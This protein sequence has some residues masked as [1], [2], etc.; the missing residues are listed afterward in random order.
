MNL[1]GN[2]HFLDEHESDQEKYLKQA[3][4]NGDLVR[5]WNGDLIDPDHAYKYDGEWFGADEV[6][7]Y[8]RI[9]K[10]GADEVLDKLGM[11]WDEYFGQVMEDEN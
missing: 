5:D 3:E 8:V 10:I 7:D 2:E 9:R 4:L 11:D 6:K 1:D